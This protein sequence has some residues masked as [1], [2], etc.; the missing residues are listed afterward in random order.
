MGADEGK[1]TPG[2]GSCLFK[3]K[4]EQI[5]HTSGRSIV[6]G[7]QLRWKL[8]RAVLAMLTRSFS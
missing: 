1:E 8:Q 2:E 3:E 6:P 7:V 5:R 4:K